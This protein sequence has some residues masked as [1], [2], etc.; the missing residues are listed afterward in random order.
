LVR[1]DDRLAFAFKHAVE[2]PAER[3]LLAHYRHYPSGMLTGIFGDLL[4]LN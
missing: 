2:C 1:Q 4:K 3:P